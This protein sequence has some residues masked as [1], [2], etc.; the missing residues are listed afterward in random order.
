MILAFDFLSGENVERIERW[1]VR[2]LLSLMVKAGVPNFG[3][4]SPSHLT[5]DTRTLS[6]S[7]Q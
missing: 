7:Y 6:G 3:R 1:H 4:E 5:Q 2:L